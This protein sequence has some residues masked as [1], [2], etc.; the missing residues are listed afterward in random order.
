[1]PRSL[2]SIPV[3]Q[4]VGAPSGSENPAVGRSLG[5]ARSYYYVR[6]DCVNSVLCFTD[7]LVKC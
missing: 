3:N 2:N 5:T 7:W 4:L 6:T 1:M